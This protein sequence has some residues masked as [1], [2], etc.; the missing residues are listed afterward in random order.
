MTTINSVLGPLD[1]KDLG[2]TLMHEHIMHSAAG[3]PQ[4]YPELLGAGYVEQIMKGLVE[5]KAAGISTIVDAT[6]MDL[7]RDVNLL[8]EVS[9]R[10]GVNIIATTG[11]W[12][13]PPRYLTDFS[14]DRL[15]PVFVREIRQ[16]IAGTSIKA[17]IL[18]GA[19]DKEGLTPGQATI[20]RAIARAHHQ[21]GV[22]II[23]HTWSPTQV[24]RQQ[25]AVLK[26]ENVDLNRVKVDHSSESTDIPYLTWL[27]DQGCYLG[28]DRGVNV[29]LETRAKTLKTL[30]DAG[31]ADR[32]CPSHDWANASM[33]W[34]AMPSVK[35]RMQ[36]A[37]PHGYLNTHRVF[38]PLLRNLGVSETTISR[39]GVVGPRSFFEGV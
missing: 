24:A 17:G 21:T 5:A 38:F 12:T 31:Y 6:T 22:P 13:D 30:L 32:I 28:W 36:Q 2:F 11:I 19:S 7:G 1:T 4:N 39:L 8:A 27:L 3:I 26:E 10:S 25:L 14:P 29:T 37:N 23:L 35:Q 15:A 20:L 18:K 9:R 33:W 16:G 34:E